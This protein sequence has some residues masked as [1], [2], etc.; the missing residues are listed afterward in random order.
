MSCRHAYLALVPTLVVLIAPGVIVAADDQSGP[1]VVSA[2]RLGSEPFQQP[3]AIYGV[4]AADLRTSSARTPTDELASTPGVFMQRTAQ[5]QSSPYI[6]GLTGEQTLL[7]FDGVRFNHATNR[8][9][10]NQY[11][12]LIPGE[13]VGR[14][15]T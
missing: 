3:Y 12:A 10:P 13:S 2:T 1:L 4:D 7:L 9:G 5:A 11:A 6:R 14:I 8:P 15:D